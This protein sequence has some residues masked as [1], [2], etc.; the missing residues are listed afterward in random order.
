MHIIG[1]GST[2]KIYNSKFLQNGGDIILEENLN[3]VITHTR[4]MKNV[5]YSGFCGAIVCVTNSNLTVSHSTFNN[6]TGGILRASS[7]E[8]SISHSEFLCNNG[9]LWIIDGML[10]T[11][12]HSKFINNTSPESM[13]YTTG[14]A[15]RTEV[16]IS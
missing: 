8:V 5:V 15:N 12:D 1:R 14:I 9:G 13:L 6:N 2:V 10:A 3:M 11:I 16:S 4:F 7:T